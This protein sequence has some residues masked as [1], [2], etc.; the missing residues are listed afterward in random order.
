MHLASWPEVREDLL[1][2]VLSD[3]MALVRRL[4]E[5]GRSARASSGVKTRQP[6]GRAL[7]GAHGW[8][9]LPGELRGLVAEELNVQTIEDMSGFSADLVSYTIK[10]NFRALGKRFGSQ[11]KLVAAAVAAADPT[12][13]ARA[14]R[15]GGT[16]MVE[17]DELGEIMLGP[18]DVIVNEQPRTGW[19]V[20]TGAIG[21][22][23]G[24]TVALDLEL[25]DELRRAG[26]LREVI[27]LVQEARKATGLSITDRIELWWTTSSPDLA[28]ALRAEP[29]VVAEEVLATTMTE[30]TVD[31]L[32]SHVDEDLSLTFRLRRA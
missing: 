32:P 1:N 22:G 29:H 14:L 27:R 4:V 19:A 23:T 30:G 26:L 16:V 25:T 31:D 2:P 3:Q 6:L 20:E 18:D 5:L 7:V 17:A 10:P 11:T 9:S 13:V 21:T 15:S 12:R 24:E 8:P 28:A